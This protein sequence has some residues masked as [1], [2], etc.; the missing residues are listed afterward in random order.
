MEKIR[1]TASDRESLIR[2]NIA[3]EILETEGQQLNRRFRAIQGGA[4]RPGDAESEDSQ[5]DG[6]RH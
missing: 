4:A 2:L 6:A 3:Y 1:L 5:A